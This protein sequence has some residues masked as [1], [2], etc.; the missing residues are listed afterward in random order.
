MRFGHDIVA[1]IDRFG[2][3]AD[4]LHRNYFRRMAVRNLERAG[5]SR[6]YVRSSNPHAQPPNEIKFLSWY[7]FLMADFDRKSARLDHPRSRSASCLE[8]KRSVS[9]PMQASHS[10]GRRLKQRIIGAQMEIVEFWTKCPLKTAP[11]VHPEDPAW[12]PYS[13][14]IRFS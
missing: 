10:T 5:I 2:L 7:T 1:T 13:P 4:E 9:S 12:T 6:G 3:V 8:G 11:F 14:L